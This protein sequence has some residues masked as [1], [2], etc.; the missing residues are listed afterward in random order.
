MKTFTALAVGLL[1]AG[2]VEAQDT[3]R[4]CEY[5]P[6]VGGAYEAT[7]LGRYWPGERGTFQNTNIVAERGGGTE[8]DDYWIV[9]LN[10]NAVVSFT[11]TSKTLDLTGSA[12]GFGGVYLGELWND[13][14][15]TCGVAAG[16]HCLFVPISSVDDV[17]S[18]EWAPKRTWTFHTPA[19]NPGRY[20][21]RF[22]GATRQSGVGAYSGTITV[23][24]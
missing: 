7:Y 11:M 9:D 6:F 24:R 4:K 18:D 15:S 13:L 16:S 19:L 12:P 3:C 17:L 5:A 22:V 21:F 8:F 1:L 23:S 20:L 2:S 10:D 14:G